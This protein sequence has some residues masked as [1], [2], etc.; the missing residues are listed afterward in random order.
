M[1]G[2]IAQARRA[3]LVSRAVPQGAKNPSALSPEVQLWAE[4]DS[5]NPLDYYNHL[6]VDRHQKNY[7]L[8]TIL[9]GE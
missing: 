4:Q 9:E 3:A 1:I 8:A 2:L 7:A 5:P 6:E